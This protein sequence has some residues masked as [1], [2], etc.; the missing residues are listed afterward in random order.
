MMRVE[1]SLAA[2]LVGIGLVAVIVSPLLAAEQQPASSQQPPAERP[3]NPDPDSRRSTTAQRDQA[4]LVGGLSRPCR[5]GR[6]GS[7]AVAGL[8]AAASDGPSVPG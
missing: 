3:H 2:L 6:S 7:A 8:T 5:P 1:R 4:P